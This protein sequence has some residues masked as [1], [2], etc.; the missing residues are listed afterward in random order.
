[1]MF[2]IKDRVAVVTGGYGVLG[3]SMARCLARQGARVVILGRRAEKGEALVEELKALGVEACFGKADVLNRSEVEEVCSAVFNRWGRV[4]I[5]INAAG[6]NIAGATIAPG[7]TVLDM[8]IEAYQQVLELN[9]KGTVVPTLVFGAQM[10]RQ[11]K[12]SV[13]NISSMTAQ[14]VVT[15]VVGYS[16]AKAGIDN[17]TKWV[18]VEFAKKFGEGI[19]VNAIAPGFFLTEQNRTL[20]TLPDG[21]YSER[22]REVIRV[23]PFG[24]LGK[25]EELNGAVVFLASDD[26]CFMTGTVLPVDGGFSIF[27]GV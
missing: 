4:D 18:A 3:S 20:M 17:F 12:G 5:L 6:G 14:S 7:Q 24:R 13:I 15:R 10:A 11:K 8:D 23:T 25:P 22:A 27:S 21:S 16:S 1:M 19:R 2:D 26:S 9:L